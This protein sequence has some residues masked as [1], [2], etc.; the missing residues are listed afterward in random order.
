MVSARSAQRSTE[1]TG[2]LGKLLARVGPEFR[3]EIYVADPDD[4]VLGR[5]PCGVPECDRSRAEN[6]LCS[7]HG[8]RRRARGRPTM[9]VF[10]ADPGP[11]LNGRR[12][13]TPCSVTGLDSSCRLI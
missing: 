1:H 8:Q 4:P 10:L 13:L 9:A 3:V 11:A 7:A 12:N 6:G 2:L 5:R